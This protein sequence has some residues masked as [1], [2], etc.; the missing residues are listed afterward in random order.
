MAQPF[1]GHD[2]TIRLIPVTKQ[3]LINVGSGM[4]ENFLGRW[5]KTFGSHDSEFH[6][7]DVPNSTDVIQLWVDYLQKASIFADQTY[8]KNNNNNNNNKYF[9]VL[10]CF[11]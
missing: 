3:L 2:L 1:K 7:T 5:K 11:N 6:S 9:F 10:F 4:A 8:K